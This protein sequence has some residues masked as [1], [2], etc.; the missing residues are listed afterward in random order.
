MA[1]AGRCATWCWAKP[2]TARTISPPWP[3]LSRW[4]AWTCCRRHTPCRV[5]KWRC[6]TCSG[7]ARRAGLAAPGLREGLSEAALCLAAFR[8][9]AG[10][11]AG[12]LPRGPR[13]GFRAVKC[14][15]GPFGRGS[16]KDDRDHL[17]RRARASAPTASCW[18]MRARF[19]R[20]RG[21]C[22]RPRRGARSGRRRWF[23]EP[24]HGGAYEAYARCRSG[25]ARC[26]SP[27]A[28]P[29]TTSTWPGT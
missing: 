17:R 16:P 9:H 27:A 23:E 10:G 12:R 5:S 29:R 20:G 26:S 28:R 1:P 14:G 2:L 6:G 18:S 25:A 7:A 21:C 11:D 24:F 8:R 13:G 3:Q 15:W 19:P 4:N 22:G